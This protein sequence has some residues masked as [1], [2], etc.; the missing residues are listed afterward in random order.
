VNDK[1]ESRL[2]VA[3][4][5]INLILD[6]HKMEDAYSMAVNIQLFRGLFRYMPDGSVESDL[7][8]SWQI[9]PDLKNYTFSLIDAE[10]SDG[11]KILARHMVASLARIFAL[12][13]GMAAELNL[14]KG[15]DTFKKTKNIRDLGLKILSDSQFEIRLSHPNFL[16]IKLLAVADCAVLPIENF[17]SEL[18]PNIF[19]GAY[20]LKAHSKDAIEI[21]KWR[22]SAFESPHSPATIRYVP[23][24]R[25]SQELLKTVA[26]ENVDAVDPFILDNAE[27]KKLKQ[28]G[29]HQAV[30]GVATEVYV[31][32]NPNKLN[33]DLRTALID[34]VNSEKFVSTL[35]H[36]GFVP[37]FGVIPNT[38][39][40]HLAKSDLVSHPE[41]KTISGEVNLIVSQNNP[42]ILEVVKILTD[43]W[44][45]LGIKT[46]LEPISSDEYFR[47]NLS[48]EF[49]ARIGV[50]G[51]DY[52]D[53]FSNLAYFRSGVTSNYFFVSD[54]KIDALLDDVLGIE[55]EHKRVEAYKKIQLKILEK[56]VI[57]PLYF[58][59]RDAGIWSSRVKFVPAHPMGF[60][61][62]PLETIEMRP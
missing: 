32:F 17:D 61:T 39:P 19:S 8:K 38:L 6:P 51:M 40:G 20:K 16:L 47:R 42:A 1:K 10:F 5:T 2:V 54:K 25:D 11:R 62:L 50:K 41:V 56:K 53:G 35:G 21:A 26:S 28:K 46:I 12:S 15:V 3:V 59:S 34:S 57:L 29:W 44:G 37:A 55:S 58:G 45:A 49:S 60:H 18:D 7:V 22:S 23:A 24:S 36:P 52:P 30:T 31:V 48:G 13:S 27:I 9:S 14:I 4:P 43:I 33:L